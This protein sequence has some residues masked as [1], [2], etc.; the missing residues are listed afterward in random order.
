[1]APNGIAQRRRWLRRIQEGVGHAL[2]IVDGK[3]QIVP[4]PVLEVLLDGILN[5]LICSPMLLLGCSLNLGQQR[6]RHDHWI[7]MGSLHSFTVGA[8]A[9]RV[10][11]MMLGCTLLPSPR[12]AGCS[13]VTPDATR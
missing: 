2:L 5:Q 10:K 11:M 6:R 1:M 3:H 12:F 13:P 9:P 4:A 8:T 7:G